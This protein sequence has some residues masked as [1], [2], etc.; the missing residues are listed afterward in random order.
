M[1]LL[2]LKPKSVRDTY[3]P[4]IQYALMMQDLDYRTFKQAV[5]DPL[6]E[7]LVRG[8]ERIWYQENPEHKGVKIPFTP[9]LAIK[10]WDLMEKDE[11]GKTLCYIE[12]K[13]VFTAVCVGI[14]F[15]LR[16]SEHIYFDGKATA[17]ELKRSDVTFYD[18]YGEIPYEHVGNKRVATRVSLFVEF[19]KTDQTGKSRINEHHR[20][21]DG[22]IF[23]IVKILEEWIFITREKWGAK[24]THCL[25]EIPSKYSDVVDQFL[26][27]ETVNN[28]LTETTT[29]A[30]GN[31]T[32]TKKRIT[33]HSLRYGGATA[34][35]A[36]GFPQYIIEL[37]GGWAENSKTLKRYTGI[38]T[39]IVSEVSKGMADA[40]NIPTSQAFLEK[41]K[42][43]SRVGR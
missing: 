26:K 15:L 25:Y 21:P 32:S 19:S 14:A 3:I 22:T 37:Y 42:V 10:A 43:Q 34:M 17:R 5:S 29:I 8:F 30:L 4:G 18:Q 24:Q 2:L 31:N 35:A 28:I 1:G 40:A 16:R 13:R 41:Y 38:A 6:V 11:I 9:D 27:V 33:T 7:N 20:Q 36:A 39:A 23:C 12:K